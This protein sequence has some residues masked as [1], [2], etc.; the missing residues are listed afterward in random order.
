[1][2]SPNTGHLRALIVDDEPD[3][4][5]TLAEVLEILGCDVST[6]YNASECVDHA[7]RTHPNLIIL[8]IS[9][10]GMNGF[11]V[12]DELLNAALPKFYLVAL[13]GYGGTQFQEA[14][15]FAG[16]DKH[17]LKPAG[18]DDFQNLIQSARQVAIVS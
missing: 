2:E 12:A 8:D 13:S 10:P 18:I 4:L 17:V 1:M 5:L 9:M 6:C 14:C 16:F 3:F 11:A 7:H 15:K